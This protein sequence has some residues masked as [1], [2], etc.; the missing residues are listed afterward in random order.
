MRD[1]VEARNLRL[2]QELD[3]AQRAA[4]EGERKLSSLQSLYDRQ[5]KSIELLE[6]DQE[7][8]NRL[9]TQYA[10]KLREMV[11]I[12]A[13]MGH[14]YVITHI[15]V[16]VHSIMCS[17]ICGGYV[18]HYTYC[19]LCAFYYVYMHMWGICMSLHIWLS[20]CI[21]LCIH[22]YVGHMYAITHIAVY[23]HSIM[24]T[25]ICG[26]YVCHYTYCCLCAFY[27]VG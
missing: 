7:R 23:V 16:Y 22:A 21:L 17:C 14:M 3:R 10:D 19:Y 2:Q 25:C 15:A 27:Y 8:T 24:Y 20:M 4:D 26:A 13:Y 6:E 9:L 11:R 18:C 5:L 12:N 1:E